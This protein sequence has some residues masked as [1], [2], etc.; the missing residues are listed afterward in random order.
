MDKKQFDSIFR[1]Y[2]S[3]LCKIAYRKVGDFQLAEDLVQELFLEFWRRKTRLSN[4]EQLSNYLRRSISLK[5]YDHLKSILKEGRQIIKLDG[6]DIEDFSTQHQYED[7]DELLKILMNSI[8]ML[9]PKRK[10]VFIQSRFDNK[11][12]KE[13][14]ADLDISIKSVEKHISKA[15]LQL[16]SLLGFFNILLLLF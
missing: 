14:A 8:Q 16:R 6:I 5:C 11:S 4:I 12:Y 7:N 1:Q 3:E 2:H 15:L 10:I 13:I 9:P